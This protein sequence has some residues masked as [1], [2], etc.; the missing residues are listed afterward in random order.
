MSL[1]W[2]SSLPV[3]DIVTFVVFAVDPIRPER[4][5]L[6]LGGPVKTACLGISL[7][8]DR[9]GFAIEVQDTDGVTV[10]TRVNVDEGIAPEIA[11]LPELLVGA[12]PVEDFPEV[13]SL[14]LRHEVGIYILYMVPIEI[15]DEGAVVLA[16]LQAGQVIDR[17]N[18]VPVRQAIDVS[19][20]LWQLKEAD[21]VEV[22]LGSGELINF[23]VAGMPDVSEL[24]GK[25]LGV[26][27]LGIELQQMTE[28]L[29]KVWGFL[30]YRGLVVSEVK[31][32]SVLRRRDLKR[33]DIV[34]FIGEEPITDFVSLA[35]AFQ[36]V[37]YGDVVTL[38]VDRPGQN[39]P[40]GSG[41]RSF[42]R[43]LIE[44]PFFR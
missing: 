2:F 21:E 34:R 23:T 8:A 16:G 19:R 27:R 32:D 29:A 39:G 43:R 7:C 22:A 28:R 13:V 15:T 38:V 12:L 5:E 44:V 33:G 40:Y 1:P 4:P 3:T 31:P 36:R 14:Q 30:D 17:F 10:I 42:Q 6:E 11:V 41:Q 25:E 24:S 18:G 20:R 37:H 26:K 9:D 35:R